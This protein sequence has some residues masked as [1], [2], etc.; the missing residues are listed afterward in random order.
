LLSW[1]SL[2]AGTM[3]LLSLLFAIS[4]GCAH[5]VIDEDGGCLGCPAVVVDYEKDPCRE[6]RAIHLFGTVHG[7]RRTPCRSAARAVR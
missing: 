4:A 3:R 2:L 5:I 6:E 7:L 1:R